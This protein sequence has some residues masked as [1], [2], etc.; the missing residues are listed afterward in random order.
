MEP[1]AALVGADSTVELDSESAVD[2]EASIVVVPRYAKLD[3]PL[4]LDD[5]L[6]HWEILRMSIHHRH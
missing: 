2:V 5:G 3:Y 4:C 1:Q 6:D